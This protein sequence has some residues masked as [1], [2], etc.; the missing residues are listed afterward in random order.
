MTDLKL[1]EIIII[2][3]VFE[4]SI[5][6][7]LDIRYT[8]RRLE[9]VFSKKR[10]AQVIEDM[11]RRIFV[12]KG[13]IAAG[14]YEILPENLIEAITAGEK[15]GHLDVIFAEIKRVYQ[16]KQTV[17][18]R[19]QKAISYPIAII[20]ALTCIFVAV[21]IF[22]IPR[23][24][25]VFRSIDQKKI[26]AATKTLFKMSVFLRGHL[27]LSVVLLIITGA[28]IYIFIKRYYHLLYKIPVVSSVMT[29][30]ENATA[31]LLLAVFHES[32]I[33]TTR[34]L[35]A[36][37]QSLAGPLKRILS[38]AGKAM[39]EGNS[40]PKSFERGGA[41]DDVVIYL[42]VGDATGR[43]GKSFKKLSEIEIK[44]LDKMMGKMV[45]TL[46]VALLLVAGLSIVGL[47]GI[48][49]YPIYS[50]LGGL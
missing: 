36:V 23:F 8:L 13:T 38:E 5:A 3:E 41:S 7:G 32:G 39:E 44:S 24:A 14:F 30:Q 11:R 46:N 40:V 17:Y 9:S 6:D 48:T 31:Y 43:I 47:F 45:A 15:S 26:P 37:G 10:K 28:L 33:N 25:A 12:E 35:N 42:E 19:T 22:L 4:E 34:S 18:E 1:E 2:L 27:T 16:L 49:V 50:M 21:L 20:I 29:L